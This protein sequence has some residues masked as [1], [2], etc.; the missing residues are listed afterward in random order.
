L[1]QYSDQLGLVWKD[2]RWNGKAKQSKT[3]LLED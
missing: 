3:F 1:Q 2:N